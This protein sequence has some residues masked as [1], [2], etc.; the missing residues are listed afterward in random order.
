MVRC[1]SDATFTDLYTPTIGVDYEVAI[2]NVDG[3]YVKGA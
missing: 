3:K 2:I 1:I